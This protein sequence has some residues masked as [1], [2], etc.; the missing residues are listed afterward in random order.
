[1]I[2]TK[3]DCQAGRPFFHSLRNIVRNL[4]LPNVQFSQ[5]FQTFEMFDSGVSQACSVEVEI[6]QSLRATEML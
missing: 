4:R 3:I 5:I 1:M 6:L 2:E